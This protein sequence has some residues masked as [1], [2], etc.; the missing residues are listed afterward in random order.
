MEPLISI[1]IPCYNQASFLDTSVE[2]VLNQTY[3]NFEIIIVN[4]GSTDSEDVTIL[5]NYQ[6]PHTTVIHIP[7][8]GLAQARNIGIK[9]SNGIYILPLDADDKIAPTYLQKAVEILE[10]KSNVG[11]VYCNA[12][13]FGGKEGKWH[14]KDFQVPQILLENTIFCSAFFR[15]ADWRAVNGYSPEMIYG[16]EDYDL[17]LS[18]IE[19]GREV[20]RIDEVLF[21]YRVQSYS[22]SRELNKERRHYSYIQL[23]RRHSQLYKSNSDYLIA[24]LFELK[25]ENDV[26]LAKSGE[27]E[28]LRTQYNELLTYSKMVEREYNGKLRE[29]EDLRTRLTL[30]SRVINKLKNYC[31][32]IIKLVSNQFH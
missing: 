13:L 28:E 12:E 20:V 31:N 21:F 26:L 6:K 9:A 1:I 3:K 5:Q 16:F 10:T 11:I 17:W 14:L 8:Q 22:M 25:L 29:L 2:S 4:D 27:L 19:L 15:K 23:L 30:S 24:C 7:N 32:K 18:I